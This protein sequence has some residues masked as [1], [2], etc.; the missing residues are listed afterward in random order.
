MLC[1]VPGI[2]TV[3]GRLY[4]TPTT[5]LI[6]LYQTVYLQEALATAVST[7]ENNKSVAVD[8]AP[9]QVAPHSDNSSSSS[10]DD[11]SS[12]SS[13]DGEGDTFNLVSTLDNCV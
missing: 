6:K 12:D 1:I 4:C 11:S 9:L 8:H 5:V 13:S 10:S 2:C 3:P 7:L